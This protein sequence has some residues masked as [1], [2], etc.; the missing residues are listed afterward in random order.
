M[1]TLTSD[2][3]TYIDIDM[4][5][6]DEFIP[7]KYGATCFFSDMDA[8]YF[9]GIFDESGKQIGDFSSDDSVLVEENFQISWGD[10]DVEACDD[11]TGSTKPRYF[12]N[13]ISCSTDDYK[14]YVAG[15]YDNLMRGLSDNLSTDSFDAVLHFAGELANDGC[16]IEIKN[17]ITGDSQ[18]YDSNVWLDYIE[19]GE[20]PE[21]VYELA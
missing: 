2:Y 18:Y 6:G 7:G 15:Y 21:D 11:I 14:Y 5:Y 1:I 13:M 3:D 17:L 12:A 20:V 16:F 8:L 4:W 19:N 10:E 9:G